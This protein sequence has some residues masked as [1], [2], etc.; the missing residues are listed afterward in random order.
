MKSMT[1][2]VVFPSPR[3]DL[4]NFLLFSRFRI[5][6]RTL[7]HQYDYTFDWTM[8]K[9]RSLQQ[10]GIPITHSGATAGNDESD[11]RKEKQPS[12]TELK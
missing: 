5:L 2:Q 10:P 7:N 4:I 6:F 1:S 11:R 3:Q 9:Q 8:L 12:E